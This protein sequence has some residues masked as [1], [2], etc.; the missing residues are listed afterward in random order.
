MLVC[1]PGHKEKTSRG[2]G[3]KNVYVNCLVLV[4]V[5]FMCSSQKNAFADYYRTG[6]V[7]VIY[8]SWG[9]YTRIER[10]DRIQMPDGQF[11]Q[12]L[13][14][15][16]NVR[17]YQSR[18]RG[19]RCWVSIGGSILP[20]ILGYAESAIGALRGRPKFFNGSTFVTDSAESITFACVRR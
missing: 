7:D 4:F 14:Y 18:T 10:V 15:F 12:I 11:Y 6:P 17:E 5:F 3:M 9:V 19:G 20:G 8:T 16:S 2:L 1:G 13:E